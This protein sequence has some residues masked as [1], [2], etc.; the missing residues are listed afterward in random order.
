MQLR[1]AAL[2][3]AVTVASCGCQA[4][5]VLKKE[6][7]TGPYKEVGDGAYVDGQAVAQRT[8]D[9][10]GDCEKSKSYL[11]SKWD[12]CYKQDFM[13][14]SAGGKAPATPARVPGK[15]IEDR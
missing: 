5:T 6:A 3:V 13:D 11:T 14:G 9:V 12:D 7:A 8:H 1:R 2:A 15:A 10:K 4:L